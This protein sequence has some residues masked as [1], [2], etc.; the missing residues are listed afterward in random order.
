MTKFAA[1]VWKRGMTQNGF[2][3]PTIEYWDKQTELNL[4]CFKIRAYLLEFQEQDWHAVSS[5]NHSNIFVWNDHNLVLR[6][7][8]FDNNILIAVSGIAYLLICAF[9][10]CR[11]SNINIWTCNTK[12]LEWRCRGLNPGPFTCKANALPLS[13]IPTYRLYILVPMWVVSCLSCVWS[14]LGH[15]WWI[16]WIY[17]FKLGKKACRRG[18]DSNPRGET[19]MD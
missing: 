1:K 17:M 15:Y 14:M 3:G 6:I 10:R 7:K 13:Y 8:A 2:K 19:P 5:S 18:W 16:C 12:T 11:L 4:T 9:C